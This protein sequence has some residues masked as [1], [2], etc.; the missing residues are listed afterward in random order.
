MINPIMPYVDRATNL[1]PNFGKGNALVFTVGLVLE[2]LQRSHMTEDT[3]RSRKNITRL[4]MLKATQSLVI[5]LG[6]SG[7]HIRRYVASPLLSF[8]LQLPIVHDQIIKFTNVTHFKDANQTLHYNQLTAD[9]PV[10]VSFF[11]VAGEV[12]NIASKV[13]GSLATGLVVQQMVTRRSTGKIRIVDSVVFFVLFVF[14][15]FV[16]C[17]VFFFF[18]FCVFFL[19]SLKQQKQKQK[20]KK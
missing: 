3:D 2:T 8:G 16:F 15:V 12:V 4:Q 19:L 7:S 9:R 11:K 5:L 14:F 13:I 10:F 17:F 1:V 6:G 18:F 20:K